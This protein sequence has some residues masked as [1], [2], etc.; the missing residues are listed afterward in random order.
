MTATI[1]SLTRDE[2]TKLYPRVFHMAEAGSWESI[3]KHGLRSTTALLDL[4]EYHGEERYAIE[5]CRRPGIVRIEHDV[6]GTAVIRDN[7]PMHESALL[8]CLDNCTP[9]EWYEL[10][11]RKVFFWLSRNRLMR[12]L[13]AK[14][15]RDKAHT[16]ITVDTKA[17]L[18]LHG[19]RV[20]LAPINTG[21]TLYNPVRR[22]PATFSRIEDYP[23]AE[24][25]KRHKVENAVV[26]LTVE[27]S[28]PEIAEI[29]VSVEHV[30]DGIS[31]KII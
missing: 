20:R 10:L 1:R 16:V 22:G 24:R 31:K 13:G 3:T 4:F 27:Y 12:L 14:A 30:E 18:A 2:L 15:Y 8:K 28:I 21:S 29:A 5:S 26:E 19:D 11:N 23:Y 7:I 25:R 9:R 17:L 6:F